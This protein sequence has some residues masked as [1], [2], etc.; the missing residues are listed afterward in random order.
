VFLLSL[1][2][3]QA[4]SFPVFISVANMLWTFGICV[5]VG[6][7]AGIIPAYKAAQMDPVE[8]IRSK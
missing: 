6:V 8:A 4:L 1:I 7:I 5:L 2:L 3:T